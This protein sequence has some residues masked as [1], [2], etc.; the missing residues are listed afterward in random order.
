MVSITTA[1]KAGS[2]I[3]T[4]VQKGLLI[5]VKSGIIY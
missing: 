5:F 3:Y 4:E 1:E 2:G